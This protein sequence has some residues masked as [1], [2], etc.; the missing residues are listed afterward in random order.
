MTHPR[1]SERQRS[2]AR[3]LRKESIPAETILWVELRSRRFRGFKFRRQHEFGPYILDFFSLQVCLCIELD[4]GQHAA[5]ESQ[6]YDR[7]RRQYL[8]SAGVR[9]IRFWNNDVLKNLAGVLDEI[10]RTLA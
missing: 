1:L 9:E 5:A 3:R 8:E 2:N 4:G 7:L 6:A 10:A